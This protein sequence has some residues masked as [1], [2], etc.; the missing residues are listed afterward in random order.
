MCLRAYS[1]EV[2]AQRGQA[3]GLRY[4]SIEVVKLEVWQ[5]A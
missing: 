1:L 4:H 5:L 2:E 3:D